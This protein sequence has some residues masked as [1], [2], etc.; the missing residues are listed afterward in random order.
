MEGGAI[1]TEIAP[2]S[3]NQGQEI[4]LAIT[5]QNTNWQQGF[6]QFSIAGAGGDI[7]INYVVINSSDERDRRDHDRAG[8]DARRPLDLHGDRRRSAG[9][10]ERAGRHRRRAR[11]RSVSPGSARAGDTAVNVQIAGLHTRWL[12]G[13]TTVDFGPGVTVTAFTVNSDTSI[14]AVVDVQP[15]A[16][17]GSA[18][19]HRA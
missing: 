18:N 7:R 14:T 9:T 6:T 8:R 15:A 16:A 2:Q 10:R 11:H 4:V 5:G 12:T 19:G 3:G 13:T 17:L 1:I